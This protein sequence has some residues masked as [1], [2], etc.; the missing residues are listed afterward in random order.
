MNHFG[1]FR[2]GKP[3][4][5]PGSENSQRTIFKMDQN[6]KRSW[7][8]S[9]VFSFWPDGIKEDVCSIAGINW[10][11]WVYLH[12]FSNIKFVWLLF[13]LPLRICQDETH[14]KIFYG[15]RESFHWALLAPSSHPC[16]LYNYVIH[17]CECKWDNHELCGAGIFPHL[18]ISWSNIASKL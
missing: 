10:G 13:W 3:R 5:F 17:T 4:W 9:K 6:L 7:Q 18:F 1:N 2:L 11:I 14:T 16:F 8:P 12:I 15:K